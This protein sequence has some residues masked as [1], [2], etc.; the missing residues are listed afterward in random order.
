MGLGARVK[1]SY[2]SKRAV[3]FW[4]G[5]AYCKEHF[6]LWV[7]ERAKKV[8]EKYVKPGQKLGVAVSGGKDS[9][10]ALIV[11][12]EVARERGAEV[13]AL[14]IDEGIAGYRPITTEFIKRFSKKLGVELR[15]ASF[16]DF[17]GKSLDELVKSSNIRPCTICGVFRRYLLNK[18]AI[19]E[20]LDYLV[21]G[22]NMDDEVQTFFMNLFTGNLQQLA[23]KGELA[24][25]VDF[26][27][28]VPRLKPLV[29]LPEKATML[30]NLLFLHVPDVECPY[31]EFSNRFWIR[32]FV[33]RLEQMEQGA[34]EKILK[35]YYS[36]LMPKIK[37]KIK[38]K[39]ELR[40]C[41]I[42]GFPTSRDICKACKLR[43]ELG[44]IRDF[45]P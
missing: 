32:K 21:L 5:K 22:H 18:L 7:E 35:F 4:D 16:K 31:R 10:L 30:Y 17:L 14:H 25:V 24:K 38:G 29:Y 2:C 39:A 11:T 1:C 23:R 37:E 3:F 41:R 28:F 6:K 27:G 43:I 12:R 40:R 20:K 9:T 19:E 26:P 15:I 42:C 45:K 8:L 44:L 33:Y 36:K 13:I 34:M